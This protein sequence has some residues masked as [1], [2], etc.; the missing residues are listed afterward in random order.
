ML[1]CENLC[2]Y[3]KDVTALHKVNVSVER[4]EAIAL[5]GVNGA[6]KTSLLKSISGVLPISGRVRFDGEDITRSSVESRVRAGI[7]HVPE[8]RKIFPGLT[9]KENLFVGAHIRRQDGQVQADLDRVYA[10][11]PRLK[12][13]SGQLGWSLSGGEQQMLAIGRGLM[14][15]PKVLLLDE[16]SLG[17]APRLAEEVYARISDIHGDGLTVLLVEQNTI[18][19]LSV[20][21]RG[22]VLENGEVVLQ[23]SA[24]QLKSDDR[25]REA[26]LG[27]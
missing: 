17:L 12:E 10:L 18:L 22:Y 23:G 2:A 24:S 8:G 6:G 16:P 11:F 5:I 7:A 13:R 20:A 1:Q 27:R 26:Y 4:G 19:A 14:A 9:V 21:T 15:R 25:V 3:Y